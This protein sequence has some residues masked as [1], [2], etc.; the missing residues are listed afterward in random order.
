MMISFVNAWLTFA[1]KYHLTFVIE[2][3]NR[4]LAK[5]FAGNPIILQQGF[6]WGK[7]QHILMKN[8]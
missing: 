2:G 1:K 4:Q 3:I 8:N 5:K 7:E 6:Y